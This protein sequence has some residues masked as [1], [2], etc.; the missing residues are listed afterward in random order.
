MSHHKLINVPLEVHVG[1]VRHH[2]RDHL[3]A[4]VL[5]LL[6][7]L[8]DGAD[9]VPAVRVPGDVLVHRLQNC[10]TAEKHLQGT[11]ATSLT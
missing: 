7:G 3:E 10:D 8:G 9:G 11:N 2:V 6:E 5:G 1:Q 4:G